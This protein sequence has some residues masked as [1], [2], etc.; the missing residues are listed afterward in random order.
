MALNTGI[1]V[2]KRIRSDLPVGYGDHDSCR[3]SL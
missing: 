3:H 2:D 1:E